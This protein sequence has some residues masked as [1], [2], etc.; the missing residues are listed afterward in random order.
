MWVDAEQTKHHNEAASERI[1][2]AKLDQINQHNAAALARA[3]QS[4]EVADAQAQSR[5]MWNEMNSN[6]A[7]SQPEP[8]NMRAQSPELI[9]AQAR[10]QQLWADADQIK[11]HNEAASERI[12]QA[13]MR[14]QSPGLSHAHESNQQP[15]GNLSESAHRRPTTSLLDPLAHLQP[16]SP[17]TPT[18]LPR[19]SLRSPSPA[20]VTMREKINENLAMAQ[21]N[22]ESSAASRAHEAAAGVVVQAQ[23]RSLEMWDSINAKKLEVSNSQI[24]QVNEYNQASNQMWNDINAK[25][26]ALL[27]QEP[28]VSSMAPAQ[29]PAALV[30]QTVRNEAA[31]EPR[32]RDPSPAAIRAQEAAAGVA[33][34]REKSRQMWDAVIE[35]KNE[36]SN[37]IAMG[38]QNEISLQEAPGRNQSPQLLR[39]RERSRQ[40]WTDIETDTG[41]E[42]KNQPPELLQATDRTPQLQ[43]RPHAPANHPPSHVNVDMSGPPSAIAK[44]QK[45]DDLALHVLDTL[46]SEHDVPF[47]IERLLS[48]IQQNSNVAQ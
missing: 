12:K 44:L 17:A 36:A 29:Q 11:H 16:A 1:K 21:R 14:A 7:K 28:H 10:S 30:K 23:E 18:Q 41:H 34:A 13:N 3:R 25:Q 46:D 5:R 9:K 48:R 42:T 27:T 8:S 19:R 20:L 37:T 33:E 2:Q 31:A 6:S 4:T 24:S 26:S 32:K 47:F 43:S 15:S 22:E 45:V 40:M 35:K 39:A 38:I